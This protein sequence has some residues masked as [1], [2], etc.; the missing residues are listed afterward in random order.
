MSVGAEVISGSYGAPGMDGKEVKV[1]KNE[2]RVENEGSGRDKKTQ[3]GGRS[4]Y[5]SPGNCAP[6]RELVP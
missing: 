3:A 5:V 2:E 6:S 1:K 4:V